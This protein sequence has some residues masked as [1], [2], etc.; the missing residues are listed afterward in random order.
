MNKL[1]RIL[2]IDDDCEKFKEDFENHFAPLGT[3]IIYCKTK[4]DGI[5]EL[6]ARK[7]FDLVLLDWFLED[8]ESCV[9]STSFLAALNKFLFIPVFIWTHQYTNFEEEY[10]NDNIPYPKD[11]IRGISKEEIRTSLLHSKISELFAECK[12]AHLS[13]IY[14]QTL[15]QKL[16]EVFFELSDI[17]G[18][19]LL[20]M[21]KHVVGDNKNIDWSNDLILNFMHRKLLSDEEFIKA[22]TSFM[23]E[24]TGS[25]L[26]ESPEIKNTFVNK[27][28]YYK[29]S[30]NRLRCGDIID[31]KYHTNKNQKAIIVNPDCDLANA[32]TRYIELIELRAIDD[33]EVKLNSDCKK[34]IKEF[35]HPSYYYFPALYTNDS[36]GDHIALLKSKI[37][38]AEKIDIS[39]LTYPKSSKQLNYEDHFTVGETQVEINFICCLDDPYKS[40][41]L[42]HLHS[43][44]LR[45]GIPD[46]KMLWK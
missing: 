12:V 36:F 30:P 7:H 10:K 25:R 27:L 16:E 37:L 31:I 8:S 20:T 43:H 4:D 14:R 41:F 46:I 9:I 44:N 13:E 19:N 35:N 18:M 40:D 24:P 17:S 26:S 22:I 2:F 32:N 11:L 28:M 38:L 3:E 45:I 1:K 29:P 34:R 39:S 21:I 42:N 6:N 23:S 5:K 33:G 15:Y